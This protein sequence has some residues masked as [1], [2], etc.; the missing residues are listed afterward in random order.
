ME[1]KDMKVVE[2]EE[3]DELLEEYNRQV[4]NND[5]H[6]YSELS[7]RDYSDSCCC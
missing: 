6:A 5:Q 4:K 2:T 3:K 7:H 1:R